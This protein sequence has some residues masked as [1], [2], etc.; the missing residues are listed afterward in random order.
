M[1]H[2]EGRTA[3]AKDERIER[4]E[5]ALRG[6]VNRYLNEQDPTGKSPERWGCTWA[7]YDDAR[8]A[9]EAAVPGREG[10]AL[11][12]ASNLRQGKRHAH[13][14]DPRRCW[15]QYRMDTVLERLRQWL[16]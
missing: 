8:A 12:D 4:L 3:A 14:F 10:K 16:V 9:L 2:R 1:G 5:G 7:M 15:R 6:I 11:T 13:L